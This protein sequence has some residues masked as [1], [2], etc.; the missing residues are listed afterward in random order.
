MKQIS[1]FR[2]DRGPKKYEFKIMGHVIIKMAKFKDKEI[3]KAGR[4]KSCTRELP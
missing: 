1:N 3:L 2:K 4:K